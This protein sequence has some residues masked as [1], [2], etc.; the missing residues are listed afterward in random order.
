MTLLQIEENRFFRTFDTFDISYR[1]SPH[2][3]S[4]YKCHASLTVFRS[5]FTPNYCPILFVLLSTSP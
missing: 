2:Q 1:I 4:K 5:T 3:L